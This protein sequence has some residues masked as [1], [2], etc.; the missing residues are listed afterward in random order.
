MSRLTTLLLRLLEFERNMT[1]KNDSARAMIHLCHLIVRTAEL[2][3]SCQHWIIQMHWI[4]RSHVHGV[5]VR[6]CCD[7]QE[8]PRQK[9]KNNPG[10]A[11]V[12]E[13]NDHPASTRMYFRDCDA[14]SVTH[15]SSGCNHI[16]FGHICWVTCAPWRCCLVHRHPLVMNHNDQRGKMED[17]IQARW[18]LQDPTLWTTWS[19]CTTQWDTQD[20]WGLKLASVCICEHAMCWRCFKKAS[21]ISVDP[22]ISM[23]H[24]RCMTPCM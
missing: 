20:C 6:V 9:H 21:S 24:H 3:P 1:I 5:L 14:P 4:I 19:C 18:L 7:H 16:S 15:N 13:G 12:C 10:I 11:T 22:I 2:V 23:H 8:H 17:F